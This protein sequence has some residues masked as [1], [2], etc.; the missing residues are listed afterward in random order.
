MAKLAIL[1]PP[2]LTD[3]QE[4]GNVLEGRIAGELIAAGKVVYDIAAT[5]LAGVADAAVAGKHTPAGLS[6]QTDKAARQSCPIVKRGQVNGFDLSALAFGALVYLDTTGDLA[7]TANATTTVVVGR[8]APVARPNSDGTLQKC[9]EVFI[10]PLV[11][12]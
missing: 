12:Y 10:N 3:P 1:Y 4:N 2:C 5:G 7:D 9:L 11:N 8:V 6:L